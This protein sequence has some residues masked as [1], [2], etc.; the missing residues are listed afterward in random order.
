M[1]TACV[2]TLVV[3]QYFYW[4]FTVDDAFISFRYAENVTQGHGLTF[5]PGERVEGYTNFLWVLILAFFHVLGADTVVT[6]KILGAAFGIMLVPMT[7]L[8]V[9]RCA[10]RWSPASGLSPA[11]PRQ[12][13]AVPRSQENQ[14]R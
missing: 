9:S 5:N 1:L 12:S 2:F 8:L 10:G 14:Q 6:A 13:S 7:A 11:R 3:L 4:Y